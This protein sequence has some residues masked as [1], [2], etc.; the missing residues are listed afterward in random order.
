MFLTNYKIINKC[1]KRQIDLFKSEIYSFVLFNKNF[2]QFNKTFNSFLKR[3]FDK[4]LK[5]LDA[6]K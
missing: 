1:Q 5:S 3:L 2:F 4:L 6:F